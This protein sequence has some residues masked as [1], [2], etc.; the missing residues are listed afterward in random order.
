MNKTELIA[1]VAEQAKLTKVD[2]KA[3]V[4]AFIDVTKAAMKKDDKIVL[5]GFG[6]FSTTKR[7]ARTGKNPQTGK[8]IKIKAKKVVK[9]KASKN[10]IK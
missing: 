2:A 5:T 10:I 7:A 1:K 3:A 6:T 8:A 9:F 4:D